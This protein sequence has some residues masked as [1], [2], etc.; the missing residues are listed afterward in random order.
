MRPRPVVLGRRS[1]LELRVDLVAVEQVGGRAA[2]AAGARA[3]GGRIP[4]SPRGSAGAAPFASLI[5]SQIAAAR[6]GPPSR[7]TAR[8]PVGE[9]TLISVS[10]PSITSMPTKTRPRRFNSGPMRAQIARSRAVSSVSA[11]APPRTM[12]ERMSSPA[13]TRL[14]APS[15]SPST[16][17]MRLSPSETCGRNFWI[18]HGSRKVV[19]NR[20][21]SDPKFGSRTP[22]LNTEPP[23]K[24]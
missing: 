12:L 7:C 20:S 17:M 19:E 3:G 23:P 14:T 11:A 4:R 9:V 24:P 2:A 1:S 13:G 22:T 6:F 15:A 8:I 5:A 21:N 18:T 16:R 10:Q